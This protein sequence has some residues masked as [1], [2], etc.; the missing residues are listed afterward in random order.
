MSQVADT[1]TPMSEEH[2]RPI[3]L[4]A[5]Q[6]V[7]LD[8]AVIEDAVHGVSTVLRILRW[9]SSHDRAAIL[10]RV[11]LSLKADADAIVD[12]MTDESGCLTRR[13]MVLELERTIEVFSLSAAVAR[14]GITQTVN[15]DAAARGRDA[16]GIVKAEPIG[17]IL[18]ITAFNGPML[19][20]AHKI[21]PAIVAGAPVIIKPS[22]R[23]PNSAIVLAE[24]VVAAG[25][26]AEALAVLPVDNDATMALV[27]DPRLPIVTFTG[28]D[29]GWRIKDAAPRK[30]V[31]LELG[32]V[33]AVIV[34]ADAD[35]DM[36][37]EQCTAGGFVRSGQA[38]LAVQRIYIEQAAYAAFAE[39]I[40][41]RVARLVTGD[42]RDPATEIG[43]LVDEAAAERVEALIQDAVEK[44]AQLLC[45]G[46]RTG[47]LIQP[48]VVADVT[49][50]MRLMRVE[51]F[52]PVVAL[53]PV[54]TLAE[55]VAETNAVDGAIH[56]G[57]YTSN[58]DVAL[59]LADQVRA[60]GVII[61][62]PSAWRVD[63]MPYGG[64]GKSGF[65]REGIRSMVME[66]TEPKMVVIRHRPL[67]LA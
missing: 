60:G 61:N 66:Y 7:R 64:T 2:A 57:I 33:G 6:R 55:A 59:T 39:R 16:I 38:C 32:G 23:V 54:E 44:G 48:A 22:P 36:A 11:V 52:G 41:A 31:H 51:A 49:P 12:A 67:V 27:A 47:A 18:G 65:G 5:G 10:D 56:V 34:A 4:V 19:I 1:E 45:G 30:R 21:A 62:G 15:L 35:L 8:A 29:V 58:L 40:A 37:A 26:P 28:G 20:A 14:E 46:T 24:Y 53:A 25:W 43:P 13:D 3:G 63:Q 9:L 17:P 42:P 50:D